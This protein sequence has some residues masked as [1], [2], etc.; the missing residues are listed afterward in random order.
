MIVLTIMKIMIMHTRWNAV[1]QLKDKK[2]KI[3]MWQRAKIDFYDD[4][5]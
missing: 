3:I 2:Q 5:G 4:D 1:S